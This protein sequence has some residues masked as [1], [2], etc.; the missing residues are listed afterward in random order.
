MFE[1]ESV[2][3]KEEDFLY[4]QDIIDLF[5]L[6]FFEAAMAIYSALKNSKYTFRRYEDF[7]IERCVFFSYF[8]E[9]IMIK[10]DV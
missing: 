8:E 4:I 3:R 5:N 1:V 6:S 7:C 2:N 10:R 9:K